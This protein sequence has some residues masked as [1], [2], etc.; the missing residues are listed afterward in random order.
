MKAIVLAGGYPQISIIKELKSR[1]YKV[2]LIDWNTNPIAKEY[3]DSFY[4]VSTLDVSKVERIAILEQVDLITTICTDQALL[5]VAHVSERL[6]LPCYLSYDKALLLTNKDKMKAVFELNNIP[7]AKRFQCDKLHNINDRYYPLIVK[8]VDSNSSKGVK[9]VSSREE[10]S[11]SLSAA[12]DASRSN[13]TIIEQFIEGP[14][15][16]VDAYVKNGK[17]HILA[18]SINEKLNTD[19]A[20]INFRTVNFSNFNT[21]LIND[22]KQIA[23]MIADA[24]QLIDSP[25]LFQ[26]ICNDN[27][28]Y[29]IECSARIGGGAK[30]F[31]LNHI[32][33]FDTASNIIDITLNKRI[34]LETIPRKKQFFIN[35]YIYCHPGRF[36]KLEGFNTAKNSGIILDYFQYKSKGTELNGINLCSDRIAGVSIEADTIDELNEKQFDFNSCVKVL[37]N[38]GIDIMRHDLLPPVNK[39][40]IIKYMNGGNQ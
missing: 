23:Q 9:K 37:D 17:A 2:I 16:T 26:A 15:I 8:P 35:D 22:T 30:I 32:C 39:E 36:T 7:T 10:L 5:T 13:T 40:K 14:E 19:K 4:Q 34:E 18:M 1:N 31:L 20:F 25:M 28:L 21:K 12:R 29:V 24:F 27:R 33:K 38:K 3:A 6:G 11:A